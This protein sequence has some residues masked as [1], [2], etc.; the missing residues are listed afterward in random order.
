MANICETETEAYYAIGDEALGEMVEGVYS[1]ALWF[2]AGFS[3]RKPEYVQA[4]RYGAIPENG[5]SINHADNSY[6]DGV[7]CV[8]IIR[9]DDD[10]NVKSIYDVTLGLQDIKKIIIS[11]WWLGGTGSDGEPLLVDAE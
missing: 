4:V 8:K 11:G 9:N 1:D 5:Q 2:R 6:E 7:S 10:K 3:G